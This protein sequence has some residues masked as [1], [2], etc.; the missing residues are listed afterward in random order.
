MTTEAQLVMHNCTA[1]TEEDVQQARAGLQSARTGAQRAY[2][3]LS[4]PMKVLLLAR[5]GAADSQAKDSQAKG[6]QAGDSQSVLAE[7]SKRE[8]AAEARSQQAIAE[9]EFTESAAQAA[10]ERDTGMQ[11]VLSRA[12]T[13]KLEADLASA[14]AQHE[15]EALGTQ[16]TAA[17]AAHVAA[18]AELR[19][20]AGVLQAAQQVML[21]NTAI[22]AMQRETLSA[23][24]AR[25]RILARTQALAAQAHTEAEQ[26]YDTAAAFLEPMQ[27][28]GSTS[29]V[30]HIQHPREQLA[31]NVR[32]SR[33]VVQDVQALEDQ[34]LRATYMAR[35]HATT[36]S[37]SVADAEK[38]LEAAETALGH[39]Y[40]VDQRALGKMAAS[41]QEL[42][43]TLAQWGQDQR[44]SVLAAAQAH[45]V[46]IT[47]RLKLAKQA[48][49]GLQTDTEGA[50]SDENSES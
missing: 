7:L 28:G 26:Q 22:D 13:A 31:A 2:A 6:S 46:S 36:V 9:S 48:A 33:V 47:A 20:E 4:A 5:H 14:S 23:T 50:I 8:R 21:A 1:P 41:N 44:D 34:S 37:K 18:K 29:W 43:G 42:S 19:H 49:T 15:V 38:E 40:G 25:V 45:I 27:E 35:A 39:A 3:A 32:T 11:Q 24:G 16:D 17:V 12:L 30:E 10:A